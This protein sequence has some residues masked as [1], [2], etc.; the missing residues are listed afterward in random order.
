[1]VT[2]R[3]YRA[4]D[5][6]AFLSLWNL[7]LPFDPIDQKTF[8][9]KVLL[10]PNFAADGLLIAE[11][12]SQCVG[13][14]LCLVRRMPMEKVGWEP[15]KGWITAFGVHPHHWGKGIGRRLIS[16]A[17]EYFHSMGKKEILISPYTPNYFVPGI[18]EDQYPAAIRL[19]QK[20][21]FDVIARPISMDANI[22]LFDYSPYREREEDLRQHGIE[23]RC[24]RLNEIPLLI[25]FLQKHMP[26]DW[27][28]HARDLLTDVT[29]GIGSYDQFIIAIKDEEVIG[30]CQFE[31]EHFGPYGVAE[32]MR[33]LG[34]G[35]L[36]MAKC[37]LTMR[38]KGLHNAWILWT[39][40]ETAE[41]VYHKFGF[42][43]TRQFAILRKEL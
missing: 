12:N 16:T 6:S 20:F 35:T 21:G 32:Q 28:R 29:K 13:F 42:R 4:S 23:V 36:L 38:M 2:I 5:E 8:H 24:L 18:D 39:T 30:W 41:R 7:A 37:L 25:S 3:P 17:L 27:V 1:M 34:V 14:C 11:E 15:E 26:G 19:L 31:G 33:G 43:K 9:R 40:E 22:V 10:D